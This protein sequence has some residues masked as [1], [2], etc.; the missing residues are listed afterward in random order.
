MDEERCQPLC[1]YYAK[2]YFKGGLQGFNKCFQGEQGEYL[3]DVQKI[4][5]KNITERLA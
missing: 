2:G 3:Q 1:N 4:L 5:S